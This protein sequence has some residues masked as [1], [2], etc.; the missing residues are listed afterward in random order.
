MR[1]TVVGFP[2]AVSAGVAKHFDTGLALLEQ[3]EIRCI[4]WKSQT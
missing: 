3:P 4:P 2:N 1:E